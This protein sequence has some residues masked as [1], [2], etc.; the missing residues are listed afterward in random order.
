MSTLN[1]EQ[2]KENSRGLRGQIAE[3]LANPQATHFSEA[4]YQLL[5]FHGTYQQDDRDQRNA[6]RAAG[7]DKAWM[8]M[9]RVK[10]PGGVISPE[11]YLALD[12]LSDQVANG[13]LRITTRQ[14]IQYHGILKVHLRDCIAAIYRSGLTTWGACGDV[15]RNTMAPAAPR[16]T[17]AHADA[18]AL[19]QQ[20]SQTFLARSS[21]FVD[22]WINGEKLSQEP[23]DLPEEPIYG[24]HYLPRKFKIGIV[25]PPR[26]DVDIF[27]QDLGFI[28]HLGNDGRIEG[29]T[30]TVGGGFGMS[31][32]KLDT[33]PVLA[34]PLFYVPREHAITAAIGVVTAQRDHGN[35]AD[36]KRARLK[37][38]I[39]THGIDWFR[40]QVLARMPAGTPTEA[41]RSYIFHTVADELGWHEQG[42]GRHFYGLWIEMGRIKD[43]PARRTRAALSRIAEQLK[44][45]YIF[46]PNCNLYIADLHTQEKTTLEAI[47]TEHGCINPPHLTPSRGIAHACVALPTCGLALAESERVFP[48]IMEQ[49]DTIMAELGIPKE[50]IL[51]RMSGCPNGCSRP[52]NADF[53]FVGRAPGKYALYVGG[54]HIGDRLAGLEQ[55]SIEEKQI[56]TIIRGYLTEYIKK[57]KPAETFTAYWG[58]T[59]T[60]GPAPRPEQFHIPS[61]TAATGTA[62]SI[63]Q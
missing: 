34:K 2:I 38:V 63:T 37:Y 50:T 6:R 18:H 17:P 10:L 25:I 62:S 59:H 57:R 15:V 55:K 20:I 28:A 32:G 39:E 3:T 5:K 24:R 42:D 4:D 22:I 45:P 43:T 51:F 33:Y 29:Y 7:D 19:A 1:V 56:P 53:A 26:N 41:P 60:N 44:K 23:A 40:E 14:G 31:H 16:K 35:R 48:T 8:F 54:S 58:R 46:T 11:R 9:T 12:R 61:Q 13:T 21:A 52:Y 47:L 27:T 36:R 30:V 49:I